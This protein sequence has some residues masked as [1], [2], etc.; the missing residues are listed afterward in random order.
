MNLHVVLLYG[1][2]LS[3][4]F[5]M[6]VLISLYIRPSLWRNDAPAVVR[7]KMAPL[8]SGEKAVGAILGVF[9][10]GI[11]III[12]AMAD[13]ALVINGVTE[14]TM[15]VMYNYL[16]LQFMNL[17]DLIIIDW[18]IVCTITPSF[19]IIPGLE[20]YRAAYRDYG[21]HFK[22]FVKGSIILILPA[23]ISAIV[24]KIY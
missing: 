22:D 4:F 15:L 16:I 9:L 13:R 11:V 3:L 12:P 10:I 21:K 17:V 5:S 24:E 23:F 1:S 18:L 8:T 20:E 6:P 14:Y 19:L 7:D 2:I